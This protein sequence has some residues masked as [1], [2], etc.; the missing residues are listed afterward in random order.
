VV[1][2]SLTP[3]TAA[4]AAHLAA[5]VEGDLIVGVWAA[6]E[7]ED[8]SQAHCLDRA[9][10]L[11]APSAQL[12]RA[13]SASPLAAKPIEVVPLGAAASP[14]PAAFKAPQLSPT[15]VFAGN[16]SP[17]AGVDVLLRATKRV[18][19]DHPNLLVFIIGKGPTENALRRQA[20]A[21]D[22]R[23]AVTFAGRLEHWRTVMAAADIFCLPAARTPHREE[24][25]HA[26][27]AGLAIIAADG[28]PYD[29]LVD[30][31][32]ALLFPDGEDEQLADRIRQ[33]LDNHEL[34]RALAAA[35][36]AHARS[37]CSIARMVAEHA[38]VYH[39]LGARHRTLTLPPTR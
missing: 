33:V 31:R 24:P 35:G 28:S 23:A 4:L 13:M 32:T 10:V 3:A 30:E 8:A 38:R 11:F 1:V 36:Q 29:G 19:R 7:I 34:A 12:H 18:L 26:L 15:L 17:D 16:L 2:H 20:D 27:A 37:Q 9:A 22:L 39:R 25:L 5:A 14:S 6:A 21:L